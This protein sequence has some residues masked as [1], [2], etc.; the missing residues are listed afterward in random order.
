MKKILTLLPL[1]IC[2]YTFSQNQS[3]PQLNFEPVIPKSGFTLKITYDGTQFG[4]GSQTDSIQCAVVCYQKIFPTTIDAILTRNGKIHTAEIKIPENC[5]LLSM[6]FW[7]GSKIDNNNGDGYFVTVSDENGNFQNNT[8]LSLA[9]LYKMKGINK[10][11]TAKILKVKA[12]EI[13]WYLNQPDS[14]LTWMNKI[15]KADLLDDSIQLSKELKEFSNQQELTENDF[16]TLKKIAE[17]KNLK[18]PNADELDSVYRSRYPWG[19][20]YKSNWNKK[21]N[22]ATIASERLR[23]FNDWQSENPSD[24]FTLV[25]HWEII[26]QYALLQNDQ[27]TYSE[28]LPAFTALADNLRQAE[29]FHTVAFYFKKNDSMR[30]KMLDFCTKSLYHIE[31]AKLLPKLKRDPFASDAQ[32]TYDINLRYATFCNTYAYWLKKNEEYNESLKWQTISCQIN[33]WKIPENN[34]NYILLLKKL[35]A[36]ETYLNE[37]SRLIRTG[38]Y[39][40]KMLTEAKEYLT[41]E[42]NYR[43][44]GDLRKSIQLAESQSIE[45]IKK[46]R[47]QKTT[48]EFSAKT[49]DGKLFSNNSLIGKVVVFD[50][51]ATWCGPCVASFP[52]MEK[53]QNAHK[54]DSNVVFIFIN[55]FQKETDK[56]KVVEDF[57]TKHN[58]PFKVALD[59]NGQISRSFSVTAIPTKVI[60]DKSG[61][62]S[63]E[64][65]GNGISDELNFRKMNNMI[66]LLNKE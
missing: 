25:Y 2:L 20:W 3:Y 42:K 22:N 40:E 19:D 15:Q 50:F 8:N 11:D 45:Q 58:Y 5:D 35:K 49:L 28:V 4:W 38:F 27:V 46:L 48:P 21:I 54:K 33:E 36:E 52:T 56:K 64:E 53:L 9:W 30:T 57:L 66:N 10:S 44:S 1:L 12:L 18:Y 14:A 7:K 26:L 41:I 29:F 32:F 59:D 51:W 23:L 63:F 13:D 61:N 43:Y 47:I 37:L 55:C 6:V 31:K 60:L 65:T 34:E 62:I 39:T 16:H 17:Q 24:T